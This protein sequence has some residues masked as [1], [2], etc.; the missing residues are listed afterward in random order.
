[1]LVAIVMLFSCTKETIT[2][3][4]SPTPPTFP[5][6][7]KYVGKWQMKAS[8]LNGVD[9]TNN[10]FGALSINLDSTI[11]AKTRLTNKYFMKSDITLVETNPS[12]R[13]VISDKYAGTPFFYTTELPDGASVQGFEID[14]A[15]TYSC[16]DAETCIGY[17]KLISFKLNENTTT[18]LLDLERVSQGIRRRYIFVKLK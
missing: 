10:V 7:A 5:T 8:Y 14:S 12:T 18:D 15:Y 1:M 16:G 2:Y 11:S 13:I 3:L 4:P 9:N 6:N 17:A